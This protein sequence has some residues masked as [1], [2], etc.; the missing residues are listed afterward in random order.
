M[1]AR[2]RRDPARHILLRPFQT[3]FALESASGILLLAAAALALVWANSPLAAS[4]F[5]LWET[6]FVVG[7]AGFAID[8]SLHHWINDGLMA[9]FFFVVGLEIK[10]EMLVG[11][12]ASPRKAALSVAA[13]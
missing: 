1:T 6:R 7:G 5:H 2:T 12:L 9:V 10:R 3:F 4:Y 13:A 8:K 11:E